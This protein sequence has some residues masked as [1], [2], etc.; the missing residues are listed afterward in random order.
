MT[1]ISDTAVG[2]LP[3]ARPPARRARGRS[4]PSPTWRALLYGALGVLAIYLTPFVA[5]AFMLRMLATA[6]IAAIALLGLNVLFG[7]A[8]QISVG[9]AAFLGLGAYVAA[10]FVQRTH[11][12]YAAAIPAAMAV[13]FVVGIVVSAPALRVR[14]LYLAMVTVATGV[15]FPGV[16]RRFSSLTNG[17]LGMLQVQWNAP[18]W[19]GLFGVEGQIIWMF[20]VSGACLVVASLLAWNLAHSRIGR[21]M[22]AL[23][24]SEAA[25]TSVGIPLVVTKSI[26]FGVAATLAALAGGLY[27]ATVGIITPTQF[28][29]LQSIELLVALLIGGVASIRGSLIG[30]FAYAF[31]PYYCARFASGDL[32]GAIFAVIILVFLYVAPRGICGLIDD[33]MDRTRPRRSPAPGSLSA[34]TGE[35]T[36]SV[37]PPL[38]S[39]TFGTE[40]QGKVSQ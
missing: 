9:H 18:A 34:A 6:L 26:A 11:L 33:V 28:G 14:G 8:G 37:P 10:I 36:P 25:A 23:R 17:D 21:S 22:I 5:D 27:A 12:S 40:K 16:V 13:S 19:T 20:Y 15:V 2:E 31:V 7:Y 1:P 39:R 32:A 30:G 3:S 29:L 38:S 4:V 35:G 24:D